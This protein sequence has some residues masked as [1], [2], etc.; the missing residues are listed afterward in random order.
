MQNTFSKTSLKAIFAIFF[1]LFLLSDSISVYSQDDESSQINREVKMLNDDIA[2]KRNDV[3][4]IQDKQAQYEAAIKQK[5]QEKSS[6]N[7]QLSLLENRLAKSELDIELVETDIDRTELEIQRTNLEIADK[8]KAIT[9]NKEQIADV[10]RLI[11]KRD[12]ANTLEIMLLNNTLSEFLTQVKY[13]EDINENLDES[14]DSVKDL[15]NA[16]E[17]EQKT[18]TRK[19]EELA[20]L[21]KELEEKKAKLA[22]EKENKITIIG[23]V[24]QSEKEYQRLLA[25]AK[26]EQEDAAAEIA[27]MEKIVRAKLAALDKNK[28]E[29]NANGLVWPVAKNVITAYFHDPAYP[30][31][32]I[33]EHPAVD[34]RARQGSTLKAA[35]SGYVAR[36]TCNG[37]ASYGYIMLIHGD[38]LSTVYGHASKSFVAEDEYVVQGQAIGLSGGLPGTPGA[39]RL[40]TGPHLHFEV[41]LNGI[42]VDPLSYL[43]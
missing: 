39:G 12:N 25:R 13:L 36:V 41:R 7:N 32:N 24:G 29:F 31:R 11:Q 37:S 1:L 9:K 8:D 38:G 3:K 2:D 17:K 16:L 33:F 14:L 22:A 4:K 18:L 28:L 27:S 34:I 43:P 21:K 42:P 35:A 40:T 20:G 15:K 6:L 19:N 26:K 5:Q 23:Q 30:F 10:L